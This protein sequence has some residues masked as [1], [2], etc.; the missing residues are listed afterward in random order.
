MSWRSGLPIRR[1]VTPL[2][3]RRTLQT[4]VDAE[5]TAA[6][7]WR[8]PFHAIR[9]GPYEG[10]ARLHH[11]GPPSRRRV[12]KYEDRAHATVRRCCSVAGRGA[13]TRLLL[14]S[15]THGKRQPATV[16]DSSA[17]RP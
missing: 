12:S 2:V 8:I 10:T 14:Q 16:A 6:S 17:R 3:Y 7:A 9:S 5:N 4:S 11:A 1:F 15:S 13:L